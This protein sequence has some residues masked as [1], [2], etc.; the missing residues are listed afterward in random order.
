MHQVTRIIVLLLAALSA[1]SSYGQTLA[2]NPARL[3]GFFLGGGNSLY[4]SFSPVTRL[5]VIDDGLRKTVSGS[6]FTP[7]IFVGWQSRGGWQWQVGYGFGYTG[8]VRLDASAEIGKGIIWKLP[9]SRAPL[10]LTRLWALGGGRLAA[11][12]QLGLA[13]NFWE[14]DNRGTNYSITQP[15]ALAVPERGIYTEH[16]QDLGRYYTLGYELGGELA[17]QLTTTTTLGL[18]ARYTNSFGNRYVARMTLTYDNYGVPQP[19]LVAQSKLEAWALGLT[20]RRG[21]FRKPPTH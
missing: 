2:G 21:L 11:G 20:L 17:Y 12:P 15:I 8:A 19:P 4:V 18:V 6:L 13:Y 10:R 5:G 7:E 9:L 14:K 16:I 3:P 1:L